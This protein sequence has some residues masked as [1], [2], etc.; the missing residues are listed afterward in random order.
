M[1]AVAKP[2]CMKEPANHHLRFGVAPFDAGHN[3]AS[4]LWRHCVHRGFIIRKDVFIL[5]IVPLSG[6]A[7]RQTFLACAA[8][9]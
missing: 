9:S 5:R 4:H 1:E 8:S 2:I 3:P 7:D 6:M